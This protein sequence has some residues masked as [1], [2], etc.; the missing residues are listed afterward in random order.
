MKKDLIEFYN[1]AKKVCIAEGF[2]KEID[3]VESR[4]FDET[5][6]EDFFR[7]YVFVVCNSGMKN[8]I[9]TKIFRKYFEI[10]IDAINHPGKKKAIKKAELEYSTWFMILKDRKTDKE[11]LELLE[12]SPFIGKI[13]KYHLA[14]NIGIDCAKPD[15][16][17]KRIAEHF[18]YTVE[19]ILKIKDLKRRIKLDIMDGATPEDALKAHGINPFDEAQFV[20]W[21]C[22]DISN[23][24]GDRI[25]TVDIVLW[26]FC[27]IIPPWDRKEWEVPGW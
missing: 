22:E 4:T 12:K 14:R 27:T 9:A 13:T 8:Q 1:H 20:Q 26:R 18:G 5:S 24:T 25:G 6:K 17:L 7:E 15:R 19:K 23:K 10:G 21:I 2:K 3:M 16:H 11:R